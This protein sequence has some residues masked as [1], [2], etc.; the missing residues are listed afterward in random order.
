MGK[1]TARKALISLKKLFF[2]HFKIFL[3]EIL[4]IFA[5]CVDFSL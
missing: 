2:R 3:A 5:D 4:Q 1:E